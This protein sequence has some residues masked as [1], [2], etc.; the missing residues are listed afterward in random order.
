MP[1]EAPHKINCF[2][3]DFVLN[4]NPHWQIIEKV[5]ILN[6]D[7][8]VDRIEYFQKINMALIKSLFKRKNHSSDSGSS[9]SNTTTSLDVLKSLIPIRNLSEDMLQAFALEKQTE[10]LP[11]Q[12]TLFKINTPADS[13]IYLL[14]GT[15]LVSDKNGKSYA[16]K[17]GSAQA[18]FPLC[19]GNKHTAS[20]VAQTDVSILRVSHKIMSIDADIIH[21]D[22][23]KI[24]QELSNN[25]LLQLFS[26]YFMEE[27]LE[28]P[29]LSS[30]AVKLRRAMQKD[31]SIADAV[32][33]IQMDP[34]ISAKLI[35][36]ANCP[37]YL[38]LN[39]AKSCL[40][41]VNRIGLD[42]TRIL[43]ISFS[44]K[45]I[46]KTRPK[47][48]NK[49]LSRLWK[50]SLYLSCISY[51]LALESKQQNPEE[52]LL[53]GLVCDIGAI[54]FLN[55]VA[56]LPA[57]FHDENEI[58]QA[59]PVV[60]GIV[61]ATVLKDWNFADEFVKVAL[62]SGD[63]YQ[64]HDDQLSL[65]DI[66][67]LSRLHYETSHKKTTGLP[68][69]TSIPA[70]G[71]LKNIALSPENTLHILHDAKNKINDALKSFAG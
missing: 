29:S 23:L 62:T 19:S 52:A 58:N 30:V 67:V 48:I 56:N 24:P 50:E 25:R 5:N 70:A 42:A 47:H 36:V 46:F 12:E 7:N 37:L 45:Q 61:G 16:I 35:E 1:S 34:V 2:I 40:D 32:N 68:A 26:Q 10:V 13:A 8:K 54:P 71:K 64:N 63:W 53:A 6:F 28:I 38:T 9:V 20:A 4:L 31:I 69:I 11:A 17:A 55:F 15:V 66:V 18:K 14:Q 49:Y 44:I 60:K 41:A 33:I 43:V 21:H 65:S 59:I 39:P 3:S 57:E 51:V 22:E 27:K